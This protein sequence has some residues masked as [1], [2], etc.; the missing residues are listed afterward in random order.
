MSLSNITTGPNNEIL[1]CANINTL[2]PA[3]NFQSYLDVYTHFLS[4]DDYSDI[5]F[6]PTLLAFQVIGVATTTFFANIA[7]QSRTLPNKGYLLES[8][9]VIYQ[10]QGEALSSASLSIN[11]YGFF[12]GEPL[13]DTSVPMS[14]SLNLNISGSNLNVSTLTVN[15]PTYLTENQAINIGIT[16]GTQIG[17]T[18]N[19]LGAILNFN[20]NSL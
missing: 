1:Y 2:N 7:Q 14:G 13:Q 5:L 6:T 20:Q 15:N 4:F 10:V 19:F 3:T 17:T 9:Q 16:F 18:L 8:I 11:I 12:D